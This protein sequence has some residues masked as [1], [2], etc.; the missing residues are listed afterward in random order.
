[1]REKELERKS[2]RERERERVG[3]SERE[4]KRKRKDKKWRERDIKRER[5]DLREKV[6]ERE[7]ERESHT[8]FL[9][10]VCSFVYFCHSLYLS[11]SFIHYKHS[12]LS[13]LS[14]SLSLFVHT[15]NQTHTHINTHT[16][17]PHINRVTFCR[18]LVLSL[19]ANFRTVFCEAK[20][21]NRICAF[22]KLCISTSYLSFFSLFIL[23]REKKAIFVCW[24]VNL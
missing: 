11:L 18:C 15:L 3:E 13:P 12:L 5:D 2:W 16:L 24:R 20:I 10:H 23:R 19:F 6:R 22:D 9:S 21:F 14:L 7:I 1:V 8:L 17:L 4:N